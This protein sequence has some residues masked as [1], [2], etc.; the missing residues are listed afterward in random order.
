[1]CGTKPSRAKLASMAIALLTPCWP[2]P[3]SIA[4]KVQS[5]NRILDRVFQ[6]LQKMN[7]ADRVKVHQIG[8]SNHYQVVVDS[9][10]ISANLR[11][12]GIGVFQVLPV[13]TVGIGS[14]GLM[15]G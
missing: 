14:L 10:G 9:L 2:V 5:R 3:C 6:W 4:P 13:L 12:V 1:M 7:L 8:H 11:D 15:S